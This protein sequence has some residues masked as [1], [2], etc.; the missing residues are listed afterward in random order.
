MPPVGPAVPRPSM[1]AQSAN[2][3]G[4]AVPPY[5]PARKSGAW[6]VVVP[7]VL[8]L[9]VAGGGL[10]YAVSRS[11]PKSPEA[12]K[13]QDLIRQLDQLKSQYGNAPSSAPTDGPVDPDVAAAQRAIDNF[14]RE[15][16]DMAPP[17]DAQGNVHLQAGG[18]ITREQW[19]RARSAIAKPA[20][21]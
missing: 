2:P 20:G 16:P 10:L 21:P 8:I 11:G 15:H 5:R 6:M 17:T 3:F 13:T 18:T 1:P 7:I 19:E 4:Q 9:A 14:R 12:A